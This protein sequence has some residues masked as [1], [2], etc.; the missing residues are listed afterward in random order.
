MGC[1]SIASPSPYD[2]G[3]WISPWPLILSCSQG[4]RP[5]RDFKFPLAKSRRNSLGK[6]K[7]ISKLTLKDEDEISINS[8]SLSIGLGHE[9]NGLRG[10]GHFGIVSKSNLIMARLSHCVD[11]WFY[12][13][14]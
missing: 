6:S 10:D 12:H 13:W 11:I 1:L 14:S 2:K 8:F 5:P 9:G 7:K 3:K 4:A